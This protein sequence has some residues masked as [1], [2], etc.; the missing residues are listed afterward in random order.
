M[1]ESCDESGN[2]IEVSENSDSYFSESDIKIIDSVAFDK[3][4]DN[5]NSLEHLHVDFDARNESVIE[6]LLPKE[7]KTVTEC[8]AI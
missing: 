2:E 4:L 7:K 6:F 3:L 1:E 8:E 5:S